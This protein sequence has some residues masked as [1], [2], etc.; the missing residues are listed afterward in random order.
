LKEIQLHEYL[1]RLDGRYATAKVTI[2]GREDAKI[3]I[4]P[5]ANHWLHSPQVLREMEEL[6]L[7]DDPSLRS[8]G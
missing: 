7:R 6:L 1:Q 5:P 2:H 4:T 8:T 3:T